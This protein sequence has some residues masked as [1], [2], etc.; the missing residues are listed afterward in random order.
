M[1]KLTNILLEVLTE[2]RCK[3]IAD[4]RYSKPSAYKSGAIVRCRKG[5]IWKGL[6]E[7]I[8]AEE[9]INDKSSIKT[10]LDGKRKLGFMV[11]DGIDDYINC[12]TLGNFGSSLSSNSITMEFAFKSSYA[13]IKQFGTIN[14]GS[15]TL[16]A[17]NF[18]RDENDNYSS[19]KT[20]ISLRDNN[21]LTLGVS[22]NTNIYTNNYF[23][24]T[25]SRN[26]STNVVKFYVN[27]VPVNVTVGGVGYNQNP[28]TFSNFQYPFAIGAIN[29]R[30]NIV[31]YINSSIPFFRMYSRLLSDAEVLQNF[32][33]TKS[34]F[35][36]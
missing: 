24:V 28:V 34:R 33:A 2:D 7:E 13:G 17:I 4:R 3:R 21:G 32:N 12:G 35:G 14:S 27:G 5:K 8:S 20:T 6:K 26:I 31:N 10:I 19:G 16:L 23:V 36:L 18:N 22:M 15:S 25:V 1:I 11:L 30:G 9:A 29:N